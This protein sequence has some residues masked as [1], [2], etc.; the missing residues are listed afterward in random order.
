MSPTAPRRVPTPRGDARVEIHPADGRPRGSLVLGHGA[1]G[2]TWSSDLLALTGLVASGW[3]VVLVEQPWRVAGRRVATPPPQLDEAWTAV[4][5][6][7]REEAP[8]PLVAGGR[9]AGAR[10]ACR[11]AGVVGADALLALAFPLRPPPR[12]RDAHPGA[13]AGR[14]RGDELRLVAGVRPLL[15]VQGSTD[16]FGGP[17]DVVAALPPLAAGDAPARVVGVRGGHG[18]TARPDD[19]VAAVAGWL[20]DPAA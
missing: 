8:R 10:V 20:T 1:G 6:H 14:D 19:V 12:R 9:S 3:T 11:T 16:R 15:V 5:E 17:D 2:S 4:L 18:F 13:A 7:L